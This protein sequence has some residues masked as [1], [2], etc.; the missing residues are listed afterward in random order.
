MV[1]WIATQE[2]PRSMDRLVEAAGTLLRSTSCSAKGNEEDF[3][4]NFSTLS[5][6]TKK[7]S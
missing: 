6:G 2:E 4:I 1:A 3:P 5:V 7:R